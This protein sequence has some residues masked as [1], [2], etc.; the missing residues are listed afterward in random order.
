M[1]VQIRLSKAEDL[2]KILKLQADS[3][4]ALS[5]NYNFNQIESLIKNQRV[6]RLQI[7]ESII[8]A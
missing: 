4:R 1:D 2:E 5:P 8:V 6:A 7:N 3:L